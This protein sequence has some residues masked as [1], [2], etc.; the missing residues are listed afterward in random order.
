MP[1]AA[2][3]G[4]R[5]LGGAIVE[6]LVA[7]GY[8]V[9]AVAQSDDTLEAI[10]ARGATALRANALVPD[11]LAATLA[12]A[13]EELGGLDLIVN[14]ISV[15]KPRPGDRHGGGPIADATLDDY[16]HWGP[17]IAELAFVFLSEGARALR[18]GGSGGV[19][20]QTSNVA[21]RVPGA[22]H[23]IWAAGHHAQRAL[24]SAAG[25]ELR[26]EGIRVCLLRID[27]PIDS[28]KNAQ[29]LKDEGIP[30]EA[31]VDQSQI[32]DAVVYLASQGSRAVSYELAV[33]AS[34]RPP[35]II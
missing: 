9:A 12:Q 35:T 23:G 25:Q 10:R 33:T 13:R 3:L 18:A 14:A 17:P 11:E 28:A 22:G 21:S 4:A 34:G 6:R 32:A 1:A 2:V 24:V 8:S 7:D 30:P 19:L 20:I 27:G 15:V 26:E 31:A 16:R 29:R 5:H